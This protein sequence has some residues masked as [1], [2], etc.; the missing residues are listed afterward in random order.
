MGSEAPSTVR[1]PPGKKAEGG[2]KEKFLA[3]QRQLRAPRHIIRGCPGCFGDGHGLSSQRESRAKARAAGC[4][5]GRPL[6]PV[7]PGADAGTA[8]VGQR[9]ARLERTGEH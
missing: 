3:R 5:L 4:G 2:G 8:G 6:P 1:P 9:G 7:G